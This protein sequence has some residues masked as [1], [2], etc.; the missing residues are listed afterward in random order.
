VTS[1]RTLAGEVIQRCAIPAEPR[2]LEPCT[3]DYHTHSQSGQLSLLSSLGR[4]YLQRRSS[5]PVPAV[6]VV[7]FR[8]TGYWPRPHP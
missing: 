3:D 5:F 8:Q 1:D 6:T 4:V 2:R 7:I